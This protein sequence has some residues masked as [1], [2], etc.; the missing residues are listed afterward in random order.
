MGHADAALMEVALVATGSGGPSDWRAAHGLLEA[1]AG[2]PV[3]ANQLALLALMDLDEDGRPTRV[4]V[5]ERLSESP[6][7]VRFPG[8]LS[9]AECQYVAMTA[10]DVLEPAVVIDPRTGKMVSHPIRTSLGAVIGP[11]RENLVVRA[12]NARLAAVSNTAIEQGEPL[13]VLRYAP[14]QQYRAHLD[15]ID[16]APNQ[17]I[18]TVL[19]YLN[20][21]FRGGETRF[22]AN[23]LNVSPRGGDAILFSNALADGSPDRRSEHA[24][25]PVI[26]G[27]KWL[28]TR[29]IRQ[30]P[31]NPWN[32]G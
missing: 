11:A 23:G 20:E 7:V 3:A 15:S 5:G 1:V 25:L 22:T 27:V 9:P 12:I 31:Y 18:K 26:Q 30:R 6:D 19:V 17:R 8:L 10:Q 29:W 28:A 2:D 13:A 21:G 4:P 24:G 16:N 14:G 32:P